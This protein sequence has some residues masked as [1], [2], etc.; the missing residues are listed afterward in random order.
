M[1]IM[2]NRNRM[3]NHSSTSSQ[4]NEHSNNPGNVEIMMSFSLSPDSDTDFTSME[5]SSNDASGPSPLMRVILDMLHALNSPSAPPTNTHSSART[6]NTSRVT[7]NRTSNTTHISNTTHTTSNPTNNTTHT[8]SNPTNNT[9]HTSNTTPSSTQTPSQIDSLLENALDE[10][11][12]SSQQRNKRD[13]SSSSNP[14]SKRP[15]PQ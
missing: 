10:L 1:N 15:R 9:T 6:S 4:P 12:T 8:T 3:R 13:A 14:E 7:S 11:F 5:N 2:N